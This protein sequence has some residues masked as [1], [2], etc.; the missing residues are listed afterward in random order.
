MKRLLAILLLLIGVPGCIFSSKPLGG[1]YRLRTIQYLSWEPGGVSES[2]YFRG[3][4]G[5]SRVWPWGHLSGVILV[6]QNIA[7]FIGTTSSGDDKLFAV[8]DGGKVME[9]GR[10]ILAYEAQR[11]SAADVAAFVNAH[12]LNMGHVQPLPDGFELKYWRSAGV[13]NPFL[14]LVL[15]WDELATI[16]RRV[17]AEGRRVKDRSGVSYLQI[18]F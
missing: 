5:E 7:L 13:N 1:G 6:E 11:Q 17:E 16:M 9:V 3:R 2:L 15:T 18:D 14:P 12:E 10:P 4:Y 8:R